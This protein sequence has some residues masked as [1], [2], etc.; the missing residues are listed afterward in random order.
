M[1][2]QSLYI[3]SQRQ[4]IVSALRGYRRYNLRS[5]PFKTNSNNLINRS[6]RLDMSRD[7]R[8]YFIEEKRFPIIDRLAR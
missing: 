5:R 1:K 6:V 2:S 8:A 4:V 7:Q 3:K